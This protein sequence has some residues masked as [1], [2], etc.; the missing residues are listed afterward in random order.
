MCVL[1]RISDGVCIRVRMVDSHHRE[2]GDELCMSMTLNKCKARTGET[3]AFH[4]NFKRK[5][6]TVERVADFSA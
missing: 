3:R 6:G 1:S 2:S 5:R 4:L